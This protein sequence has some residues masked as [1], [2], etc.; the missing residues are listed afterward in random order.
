M[1]KFVTDSG[2]GGLLPP[3]FP[4]L[5]GLLVVAVSRVS[6]VATEKSGTPM[7]SVQLTQKGYIQF[8][9]WELP[10][11]EIHEFTFCLWVKSIDLEHPHSIFSYSRNE[12]E[13]LIRSWISS[14]GRSIHLEIGGLEVFRRPIRMQEHRWYHVCQSWEN[15][16]GRYALWLDGRLELQGRSEETIH[17]V[18]PGGGDI[19]LG[20]E[21]TDFDKGLEEGIEGSVLGFNLLLASAFNRLDNSHPEPALQP[22]ITAGLPLTELPFVADIRTE[23]ARRNAEKTTRA[24]VVPMQLAFGPNWSRKISR[25]DDTRIRDNAVALP[26]RLSVVANDTRREETP[27]IHRRAIIFDDSIANASGESSDAPLGLQLVK[28]SYV[29]CQLGRGSPPIGGQLML[30]SWTKT[31]VRVFGGAIVKNVGDECGKF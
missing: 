22:T 27:P 29:R 3:S 13:R 1:K 26:L 15:Q 31:P 2:L 28:L 9:R 30:I 14:R 20:Q 6:I 25:R 18:I 23:V 16:V 21:Y 5:L 19:V 24:S 12:R 11:P 8:L 10:V 17:Y 7:H 4:I